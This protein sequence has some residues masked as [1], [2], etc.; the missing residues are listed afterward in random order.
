MYIP[1]TVRGFRVGD[2]VITNFGSKDPGTITY[3]DSFGNIK[4]EWGNGGWSLLLSSQL[5]P[6][7]IESEEVYDP[8]LQLAAAKKKTDDN[9]REFFGYGD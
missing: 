2:R 6:A 1:T 4:V 3:I 9:L 7:P 5:E 8:A